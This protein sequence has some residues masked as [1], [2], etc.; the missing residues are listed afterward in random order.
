MGGK[1]ELHRVKYVGIKSLKRD[2]VC[3]TGITWTPGEVRNVEK[4][5]AIRLCKYSGVWKDVTKEV[6]ASV[7]KPSKPGKTPSQI[8]KTETE[9]RKTEEDIKGMPNSGVMNPPSKESIKK[10]EESINES[11]RASKAI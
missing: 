8:A 9:D 7:T 10:V 6:K 1:M 11:K 5:V 2:T 3:D 4:D